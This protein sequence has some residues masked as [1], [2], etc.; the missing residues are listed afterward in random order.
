MKLKWTE[1]TL[2]F[3]DITPPHAQARDSPAV[4]VKLNESLGCRE[5]VVQGRATTI[6]R[7]FILRL[8]NTFINKRVSDRKLC[9][10]LISDFCGVQH[11]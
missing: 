9:S 5:T 8:F 10:S 7:R 2:I 6:A 11:F 4:V 3:L 1:T